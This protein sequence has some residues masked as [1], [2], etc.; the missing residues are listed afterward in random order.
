MDLEALVA[1]L[2]T[3]GRNNFPLYIKNED[4]ANPK[5]SEEDKRLRLEE[6]FPSKSVHWPRPDEVES[7]L[8]SI[9]KD[10]LFVEGYARQLS[11][12]RRKPVAVLC[13][14]RAGT[15][16]YYPIRNGLEELVS[17]LREEFIAE[18]HRSGAEHGKRLA[19]LET[20]Q[21]WMDEGKID[22]FILPM[23]D[24]KIASL[25]QANNNVSWVALPQDMEGLLSRGTDMVFADYSPREFPGSFSGDR[26]A[27]SP[28]LLNFF[29]ISDHLDYEIFLSS[30]RHSTPSSEP[31][32]CLQSALGSHSPVAIML[33]ALHPGHNKLYMAID[34]SEHFLDPAFSH[35]MARDHSMG[36]KRRKVRTTAGKMYADVYVARRLRAR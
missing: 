32:T 23:P 6:A 14:A 34:N 28:G 10:A 12:G 7:I 16:L 27:H 11:R 22:T 2:A 35:R 31:Q 18:Y 30:R 20:A 17:P 9:I 8:R 13:N 3:L 1:G 15:L 21:R 29:Q 26:L 4:L 19:L 33:N 24:I 5:R 36:W 25:N